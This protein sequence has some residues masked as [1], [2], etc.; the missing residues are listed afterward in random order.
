VGKQSLPTKIGSY[1]NYCEGLFNGPIRCELQGKIIGKDR[2]VSDIFFYDKDEK[3][4]AELREVELH[5]LA[6]SGSK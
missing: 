1:H 6:E 3:L 2:S 4:V 5:M